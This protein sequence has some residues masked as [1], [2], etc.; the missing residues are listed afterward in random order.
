MCISIYIYNFLII[1]YPQSIYTQHFIYRLLASF[2]QLYI[3]DNNLRFKVIMAAKL[4]GNIPRMC[5]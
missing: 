4:L 2:R 1:I 5:Q 3:S